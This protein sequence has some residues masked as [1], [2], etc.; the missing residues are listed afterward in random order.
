MAVFRHPFLGSLLGDDRAEGLLSAEADIAAMLSFEEALAEAEAA[1]GLIPAEAAD[2]IARAIRAFKPDMEKLDAAT[3]RDGVVVPELVRQIREHV[4]EPYRE[5][6]HVGATSQDLIDT[7]F[8][9]RTDAVLAYLDEM[10]AAVISEMNSLEARDGA[11][12]V[13]AHTRMQA[14]L[15]VTAA[16]K[17]ASWRAPLERHRTRLAA[18]RQDIAV[19]HFGGPVGTL[20]GLGGKGLR[21]AARMA[22][23]MKLGLLGQVRHSERDGLASLAN[24]LSMVTGSLGKAGSDIALGA[25]TEI[26]EIKL[27][28][29]G[30]SSAMAHKTNPVAAETLIALARYNA[31]LLSGVHQ[32]LVHEN[33]RSGA[34]WTLEWLILPQMLTATATA[35]RTSVKLM[36]TI[37]FEASGRKS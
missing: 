2:A 9:V 22:E 19:L 21:V 5:H 17:I 23:K 30:G 15:P 10:L 34:A 24:W 6:V 35:L 14:A 7:S 27:L 29:G 26:G 31:T 4:E 20:D 11:V 25:Q 33:E 3:A 12:I 28:Q 13:M 18:V 16:H 37:R 8:A 32:S 1:E 36:G